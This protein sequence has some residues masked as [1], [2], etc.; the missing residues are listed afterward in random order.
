MN[1]RIQI[2]GLTWDHPRAYMGLD[3][4]TERFNRSQDRIQLSWDRHSLRGFETT[5]II[6]TAARYD[7]IIL[8]HPFMGDAAKSRCLLDLSSIE[9]LA[10]VLV[11]ENFVGP[12]LESYRYRNGLW[13][14][15]IDAACQTAA[16]R[17]DSM[18]RPP[19]TLAE[20]RHYVRHSPI[21]LALGCPHAFMNFLCIA[22]M[23]GADIAGGDESLLPQ[24]L[25]LESLELLRELVAH[26]PPECL[27]W[28]S[29]DTLDAIA[30]RDDLAYCPMVFCFNTYARNDGGGRALR[31]ASPPAALDRAPSGAIAGGTGLAISALGAHP[32]AAIE[33]VRALADAGSQVRSAMAGGQ[34]ARLEAWTNRDTDEVNGSFF[35]DCLPAMLTAKLRP[36]YAGYME[37][38][39]AAGNL[40]RAD[41]MDRSARPA[42]VIEEINA[43]YRRTSKAG[44]TFA[45]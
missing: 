37:L 32:A 7:L 21:A 33:V 14:M 15:P 18:E 13:A 22:G 11:A 45:G 27:D 41:A 16:W 34:P 17:P 2:K 8:D 26:A 23:L 36:R 9:A 1:G 40:L 35:S 3:A 29:I 42:V 39:N 12:S 44:E 20:L 6:D 38:Q 5:P 31:F 30:V 24:E 25:A 10:D 19:A 4:E 28:S 43:I